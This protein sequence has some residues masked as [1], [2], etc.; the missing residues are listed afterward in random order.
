MLAR[1][2]E[3]YRTVVVVTLLILGAVF[4]ACSVYGKVYSPH[5]GHRYIWRFNP[6]WLIGAVLSWGGAVAAMLSP[7]S[8]QQPEKD[9]PHAAGPPIGQEDSSAG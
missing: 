9:A 8:T 1:G 3:R 7:R 6:A 5:R 4:V 2:M